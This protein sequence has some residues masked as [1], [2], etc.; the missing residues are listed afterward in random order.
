MALVVV[1]FGIREVPQSRY[2]LP[3]S[4][5]EEFAHGRFQAMEFLTIVYMGHRYVPTLVEGALVADR[6][7]LQDWKRVE[8]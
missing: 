6:A 5:V 4:V 8:G 7:Y 3:G 2:R 1:F